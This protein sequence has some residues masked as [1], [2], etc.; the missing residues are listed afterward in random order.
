MAGSGRE[1]SPH[2]LDTIA[3]LQKIPDLL[4]RRG[5][6]GQDYCGHHARQLVVAAAQ[7]LDEMNW[8]PNRSFGQQI[9]RYAKPRVDLVCQ[10]A[11]FDGGVGLQ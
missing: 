11:C 7:R 4:A 9:S 8:H 1:G 6:A 2:D 3:D 10:P 5:Y